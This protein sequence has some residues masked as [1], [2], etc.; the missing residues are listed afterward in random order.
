MS[1]KFLFALMVGAL[2]GCATYQYAKNVKMV[3]FEENVVTGKSVGP[4]QGEDCVWSILG[5]QLGGMPTLDRAFASVRNQSSSSLVNVMAGATQSTSSDKAI[6]YI[7][8]VSTSNDGF[9]AVVVG[10]QCL[11]VK[12][13]GYR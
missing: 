10:K 8:G 3:S 11:I 12:G 9:N 5:Y 2:Q 13:T 6:R 4:V 7:N 1:N